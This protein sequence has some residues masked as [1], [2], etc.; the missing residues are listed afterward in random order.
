MVHIALG[1]RWLQCDPG[2]FSTRS[3][4]PLNRARA[5]TPLYG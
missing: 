3:R 1:G 5:F 4:L 2:K